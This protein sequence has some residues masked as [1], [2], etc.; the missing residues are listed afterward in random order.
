MKK[1]GIIIGVLLG[2][3]VL[4]NLATHFYTEYLWFSS[5]GVTEVFLKPFFAELLIKGILLGLAFI[6][7]LVN[8]LPL[9]SVLELPGIRVVKDNET[10]TTKSFKFKRIH[11]I[12]AAFIL[13]VMWV[14][15]LPSIWDKVYLY[16]N[17]S[18]TGVV[19]PIF[20]RDERF[21]LF[22]YPLLTAVSGSFISLLF[23]ATVPLA[24]GYFIALKSQIYSKKERA[25]K[26]A[27]TQ[28]AIFLALFF[29]WFAITRNLSMAS[30]L[31]KEGSR[32]YGAG[33]TDIHARLPLIR[34]QQIIA[35]IL[36]IT[37]LINIKVKQLKFM[38]ATAIL[39]VVTMVGS[40][41]YAAIIQNFVVNP[42]EAQKEAPYIAYHIEGT[43]RGYGLENIKQ[44]E[45]PL[46]K[47]GINL[48]VL[49]NNR[50]TIENIRLL[51]YRPLKQHYQ[52]NQ[53]LGLFYEF[54]DVD[55]DRYKIDGQYRQVMLA[56]RETNIKSLA[57]EA[58]TPVNHHFRY[59]HGYGVVMSPVNKVTNNGHPTYYLRDMP[60]TSTVGINLE[61]PEIYFGEL[62]NQFIVVNSN[63]EGVEPYHGQAG[64]ELNFFRRLL[65]ANKFQKSILLLSSEITPESR[66]IYYRNI[67]ERINKV[68]PFIQQD[69]DPYPVIAN[70]RIY[71]IVDG[72]TTASTYPY[73]KPKKGINYI[74]N[75]VKIV[76]DA[77]E[78]TVDIYQFDKED[79]II[80]A[81][82]GIFPGLIKEKEEFPE[83]LKPHIRYPL[84]LFTTQSEILTVYHTQ[85][86]AQFYNRND[87]W[88]IAVER[89]HGNEVKVEPYYVIMRLPNH[90]EQEFIL[91]RPF[92]PMNRNNMV[93]WLAARSDG[94]HYGELLLYHF[95]RGQHVE[96][97]SQIES[98]IDSDPYISS[99]MT[100]WGQGGSTVIRGNLL[101]IPINGSILYVEPIYITAESRSLPELRQVVVFY[102][103]VLVM[104]PT[105]EGALKRLFGEGEVTRPQDPVDSDDEDLK[106]LVQRINTAFVNMENAAR[107][108]QWADY[109]RYLEEVKRLLESLEKYLND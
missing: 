84:D 33:Y 29:I 55:I 26:Y 52:Q 6:F 63:Y 67:V 87:V 103:D 73:S 78:G 71:W 107:N 89:Y 99:Q 17:S 81:W 88:E 15:L 64:V 59:T 37:S 83:Y 31:L 43:R 9:I 47:D 77:Y 2:I 13:A 51:D 8:L 45:Y 69:S 61:R 1:I 24:V 95:P 106:E 39:L 7:L 96:G 72:Y 40:G 91:K 42:N 23:L 11:G 56:V 101:T 70:G 66:I 36:A 32:Y 22:T 5:M 75:S 82:K 57:K 27:K 4:F 108:G 48:E 3:I 35:M 44:I 90:Q 12:V 68:A 20:N 34:F 97:P 10:V 21:Y 86:P 49:E 14:G 79:P 30:L 92:T 74:R 41:I 62:T 94:E 85:D 38:G 109:G 65:Y 54:V 105:L 100:L 18:P 102:N 80:N 58:Q 19:D 76:V 53:S 98:Y 104:E 50:E 28:G 93:A 16:L 46:K 25:V 60:V